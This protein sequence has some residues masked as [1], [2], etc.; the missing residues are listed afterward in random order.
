[1]DFTKKGG[2]KNY[3]YKLKATI[4]ADFLINNF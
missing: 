4:A 2:G 3:I 1:M